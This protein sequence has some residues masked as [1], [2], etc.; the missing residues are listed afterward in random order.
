[1]PKIKTHRGMAKRIIVKAAGRLKR[2]QAETSHILTKKA[3][4]GKL[5][6]RDIIDVSKD[7]TARVLRLLGKK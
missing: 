4:K 6:R 5:H 7:D 1:M 2:G 3:P